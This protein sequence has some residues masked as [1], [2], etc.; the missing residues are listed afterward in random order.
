MQL[1]CM[2]YTNAALGHKVP[3]LT[4]VTHNAQ[5]I[6]PRVSGIRVKPILHIVPK[7][8]K[9]PCTQLCQ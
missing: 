6:K 5:R 7:Q 9:V 1:G 3:I 4:K 8:V 2:G